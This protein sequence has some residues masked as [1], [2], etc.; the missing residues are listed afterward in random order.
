MRYLSFYHDIS[1]DF[2][3]QTGTFAFLGIDIFALSSHYIALIFQLVCFSCSHN[4][5]IYKGEHA[6]CPRS[7]Q[8][9]A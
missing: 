3:F 1:D 9:K 5:I 4:N 6:A 8:N 2:D 7:E